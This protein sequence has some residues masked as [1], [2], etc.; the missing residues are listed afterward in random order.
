MPGRFTPIRIVRE[1]Y[2]S[3]RE[4]GANPVAAL[5]SAALPRR[6]LHD[7]TASARLTEPHTITNLSANLPESVDSAL[8]QR[9][10]LFTPQ[11]FGDI[12]TT[13]DET[14]RGSSDTSFRFS[15]LFMH[16]SLTPKGDLIVRG[17]EADVQRSPLE[18]LDGVVNGS[19]DFR[20]A[21]DPGQKNVD[22][23]VTGVTDLEQRYTLIKAV[24]AVV[25]EAFPGKYRLLTYSDERNSYISTRMQAPRSYYPRYMG[26]FPMDIY[27]FS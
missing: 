3:A 15:D 7:S 8:H 2:S 17:F 14:E 6:R 11:L 16:V 26:R 12:I 19:I 10:A 23:N 27:T 20:S 4:L 25:D 18:Q 1:R 21:G 24:K 5:A 9:A 22:I 13:L